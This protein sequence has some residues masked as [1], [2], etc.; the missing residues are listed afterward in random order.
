MKPNKIVIPLLLAGV[1]AYAQQNVQI[2]GGGNYTLQSPTSAQFGDANKFPRWDAAQTWTGAQAFTGAVTLGSTVTYGAVAAASFLSGATATFDAGS[3]LTINGTLAGTHAQPIG[4]GDSPTFAAL[5]LTSPLTGASGGTGVAN[6]GKTI[7]LGGNF[8]TSGAFGLTLTLTGATNITLPTTGTL[9]TL[10]GAETLTNKTL[11]S[12]TLTS[13][14]LG[15]ASATSL[16]ITGTVGGGFA[17]FPAQ[18]AAP[19]APASGYVEYADNSGRRAWRRAS[20]GFTRTWDATLTA[21]RTYTLPDS[22][23][24]IV[25]NTNPTGTTIANVDSITASSTTNLTL[26]GGSSGAALPWLRAQTAV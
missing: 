17:S 8:T 3:T 10:A 4:A 2:V 13:P 11:T 1:V 16:A 19:S 14:V 21:N 5:T 20:D 18:S 9:A 6:S 23:G 7:T 26:G 24:T 25:L 22:D 15:V 12:P